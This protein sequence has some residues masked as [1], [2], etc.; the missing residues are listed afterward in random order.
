MKI[1]IKTKDIELEYQDEYSKIEEM[2]SRY[3]INLIEKIHQ[4]QCKCEYCGAT[5]NPIKD[6]DSYIQK[7]RDSADRSRN[8]TLTV[9]NLGG[10]KVHTTEGTDMATSQLPNFTV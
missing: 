6:V 4:K 1:S 7:M 5:N 3:L 8:P 9:H 2:T 10:I